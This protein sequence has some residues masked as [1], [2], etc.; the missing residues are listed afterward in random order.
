MKRAVRGVSAGAVVAAIV[1]ATIVAAPANAVTLSSG[2]AFGDVPLSSGTGLFGG[3]ATDGA[4]PAAGA[5]VVLFGVPETTS[6]APTPGTPVPIVR[7]IASSTGAWD[8]A[9]PDG[10]DLTPY[11]DGTNANFQ[12]TQ[13]DATGSDSYFASATEGSTTSTTT[14]ASKQARDLAATSSGNMALTTTATASIHLNSDEAPAAAP[15]SAARTVRPDDDPTKEVCTD[16]N[17]T[18]YNNTPVQIAVSYSEGTG[19]YFLLSYS[20]GSSSSLGV[21]E[22][23]SGD[24][25]SFSASGTMTKSS[26]STQ[27]FPAMNNVLNRGY[28]TYFTYKKFKQT[29]T[30]TSA[31][32]SQT[33]V[34]WFVE[35][36]YWDGGASTHSVAGIST[37]KCVPEPRTALYQTNH[38][39]ASTFAAGVSLAG[40]IGINLTATTGYNADTS[41]D[42]GFPSSGHPLCGLDDY[43][44]GTPRSLQIHATVVP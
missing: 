14:S 43:P 32:S 15:V 41:F 8:L 18:G 33:Y 35:P 5:V 25:G 2:G 26:N 34:E 37:S 38:S 27:V 16:G 44:S 10:T 3:V 9:V 23:G 1:A 7:A 17:L 6:A 40:P 31:Q 13:F 29:C 12:I 39:V 19:A 42:V 22:S 24:A 36:D 30:I 21:A 4:T 11:M 20:S 28:V